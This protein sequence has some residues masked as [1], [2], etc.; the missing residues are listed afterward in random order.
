MQEQKNDYKNYKFNRNTS[1][2]NSDLQKN[3][4]LLDSFYDNFLR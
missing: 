1:N 4:D 2:C 3:T